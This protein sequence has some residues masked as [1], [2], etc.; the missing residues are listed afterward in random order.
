MEEKPLIRINPA[1]MIA[2]LVQVLFVVLLVVA[3]NHFYDTGTGV[4][5]VEMGGLTD[6]LDNLTEIDE[7]DIE[8]GVYQALASNTDGIIRKR[9][10]YIRENSLI[11]NYYENLGMHYANF[12]VDI[13]DANQS[14]RVVARWIDSNISDGDVSGAATG[15]LCLDDKEL[16]YGYFDCKPYLEYMKYTILDSLFSTGAESLDGDVTLIPVFGESED[17][18][19]VGIRY[20]DCDETEC[21][22][23]VAKEA[24]KKE[25]L[26]KFDGLIEKLGFRADSVARYFGDCEGEYMWVDENKVLHVLEKRVK[27]EE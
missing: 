26:K 8:S 21:I 5:K 15:V 24:E 27:K 7:T 23:R 10:A 3:F 16:I 17:D 1:I 14:Y 25:T 2:F 22:C 11:E 12:I 19:K 6:E 13:P 4:V 9:G 20:S 18:F